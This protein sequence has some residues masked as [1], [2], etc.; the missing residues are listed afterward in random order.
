MLKKEAVDDN[1]EPEAQN[2]L[3][4]SKHQ[5]DVSAVVKQELVVSRA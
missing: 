5:Q 4:D 2:N 1:D 3:E